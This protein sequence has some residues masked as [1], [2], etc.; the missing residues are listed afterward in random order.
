MEG[1]G[2]VSGKKFILYCV[3]TRFEIRELTNIINSVDTSAFVSITDVS[4]NNRKSHQENIEK[5]MQSLRQMSTLYLTL[6]NTMSYNT[7]IC[8]Q[9]EDTYEIIKKIVSLLTVTALV[10]SLTACGSS[11]EKSGSES[12]DKKLIKSVYASSLNM[13]HWMLQQRDL[14]SSH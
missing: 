12:S 5:I 8:K 3:L 4:G 9:K 2:L 1:E 13:K 11:S 14:K 7:V 6:D 10:T